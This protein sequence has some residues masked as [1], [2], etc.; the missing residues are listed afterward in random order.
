[1]ATLKYGNSLG[2]FTA[3]G[4]RYST[5]GEF[6]AS[7]KTSADWIDNTT[8]NHMLLEGKNLKYEGGLLVSGTVTEVTFTNFEGGKFGTFTGKFLADNFADLGQGDVEDVMRELSSGNDTIIGTI[9]NDYLEGHNGKDLLK[10]GL[11]DDILWSG[12][13]RDE[14]VG[15]K[16]S[17]FFLFEH[18]DNGL[19]GDGHDIVLDFDATGANHDHISTQADILDIRRDGKNTVIEFEGG[20]TATLLDVK[21]SELTDDHFTFPF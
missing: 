20:G 2:N 21:P 4:N 14:I 11:G 17:D 5:N 7:G 13:G 16:G 9:G 8:G 15:G 1:M 19:K 3:I 18:S 10:G 6:I 12:E